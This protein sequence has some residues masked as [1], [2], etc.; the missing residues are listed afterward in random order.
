[1]LKLVSYNVNGI[2]A[3]IKKGLED[4]IINTNPDIICFQ[5]TKSHP[6]QVDLTKLTEYGYHAF[7][8]SAE[9][10]GYSGVLTLS[11][12]KPKAVST[13]IGIERY[14]N[15]GRTVVTHFEDWTLINV[16]IPSGSS[17]EMRHQ[18]KMEFL[19]DFGPWIKSIRQSHP[20]LVVVG[21]YNIVHQEMD[22]HNPERKDK[23]SGYKP[24]ERA[25]LHHWFTDEGFIDAFR[26]HRPT[27]RNYSWWSYRSGARKKDK[28]WRIDYIS[29]SK[30]M[31]P[32][33][34]DCY[35][36]K[37]AVHSDHCPVVCKLGL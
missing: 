4:Y 37:D 8:H 28:G 33:I 7:W 17:G 13:G 36:D 22:I 1:M 29:V 2:R 25:W 31:G 14:D 9:K 26:H 5:E 12:V 6:E 21:D 3:A 23:P 11:R 19:Q 24:D 18:F 27:E 30:S 35:M 32:L 34:Q 20:N 15:E 10:K 16:Y